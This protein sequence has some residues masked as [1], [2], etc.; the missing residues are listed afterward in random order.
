[1]VDN[2]DHACLMTAKYVPCTVP[3]PLQGLSFDPDSET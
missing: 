2:D 1:M 3:N